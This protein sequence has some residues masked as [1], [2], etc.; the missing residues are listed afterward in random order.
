MPFA[1][2]LPAIT[3]GIGALGNIFGGA[4]KGSQDSR[5]N[6]DLVNAKLYDTRVQGE[7]GKGQLDLAQKQFGLTAPGAQ[8]R[9]VISADLLN[10]VK[11]ATV[12]K[13]GAWGAQGGLR[14]SALGDMSKIA[15]LLAARQQMGPLAGGQN[16]YQPNFGTAPQQSKAGWFEKLLGGMGLAGSVVGGLG[17]AGLLGGGGGVQPS[18]P[19]VLPPQVPQT[20]TFDL[21][22]GAPGQLPS[23]DPFGR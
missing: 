23:R 10:N 1:A 20:R 14:P 3:A 12:G 16:M 18:N 2:F 7:L 11:D 6:Q 19:N 17:Q 15:A 9:T 4:A 8:A 5:L 22:S 21:F 13:P